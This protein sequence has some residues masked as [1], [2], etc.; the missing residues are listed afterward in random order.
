MPT[1]NASQNPI[2]LQIAETQYSVVPENRVTIPIGLVNQGGEEDHFEISVRGIPLDWISIT[3]P[4]VRLSPGEKTEVALVIEA[5]SASQ[6]R[7][8]Q[9]PLTL[10]VL[11]QT[12]PSQRVETELTLTVA[13]FEVQGRIGILMESVQFSVAPGSSA[14]LTNDDLEVLKGMSEYSTVSAMIFRIRAVDYSDETKQ[15]FVMGLTDAEK[16]YGSYGIGIESGRF[17]RDQD[18]NVVLVGN[19]FHKLTSEDK[20][21][22]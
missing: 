3:T 14:D 17:F 2:K 22:E 13:A 15:V 1:E 7:A 21:V 9:Y 18:S 11:S 10:V 12:S 6:V 5:P 4:V 8:G 16:I 19:T 20:I